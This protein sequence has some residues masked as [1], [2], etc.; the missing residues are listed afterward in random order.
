MGIDRS[1]VKVLRAFVNNTLPTRIQAKTNEIAWYALNKAVE[2]SPFDTGWFA[3]SW[4]VSLDP[5]AVAAPR[6][7][8]TLTTAKVEANA[9]SLPVIASLKF[10]QRFYITN[11]APHAEYVELGSPT[12]SASYVTRRVAMAVGGKFGRITL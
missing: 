7:E 12:T 6:G 11:G 5:T 10:G 2:I 3:A 4:R 1:G 8:R 9:A